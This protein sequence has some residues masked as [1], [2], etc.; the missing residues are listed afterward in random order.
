[1]E[2]LIRQAAADLAA[3]KY[4]IALTGAGI[5]TESGIPDFRGPSGVWTKDP[6]AERRA[7]QSYH[8]FIANP[9][10]F[11]EEA[12]DRP[13]SLGDLSKAEPN[14]GHRALAALEN[15]D[16]LKCVITQNI[17]NLHRRAGSR[18]LL[19]YH[20]NFTLLRCLAC[21]ARY[22]RDEAVLRQLQ[23]AGKLP[24]TC[25]ECGEALKSDVVSFNEPIPADV[26]AR[27][28]AE[29]NR[30]DLMLICGTSAAVYPFASLPHSARRRPD[31]KIIEIN[32][33]PTPLTRGHISDFLLQGKT[34]EILPRIV[35]VVNEL[36]GQRR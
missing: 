32:A 7:Y 22:E 35:A 11:W 2:N 10:R 8:R 29:A 34:G 33:E 12:L 9:R 17:D 30:C 23:A 20:G 19:E 21:G 36:R 4:P 15:M 1:M 13:G 6:A 24:P 16:V 14:A 31:V 28:E 3:A 27:S 25:R 5:S 18:H 26:A